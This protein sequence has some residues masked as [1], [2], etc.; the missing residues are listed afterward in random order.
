MFYKCVDVLGQN[1]KLRYQPKI[2]IAFYKWLVVH[3]HEV[4]L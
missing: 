2:T 3:Q 1:A 4:I